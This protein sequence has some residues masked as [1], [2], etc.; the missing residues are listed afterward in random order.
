MGPQIMLSMVIHRD[1]PLAKIRCS[2]LNLIDVLARLSLPSTVCV[3]TIFKMKKHKDIL[4]AE[5]KET[6]FKKFLW[7]RYVNKHTVD[8]SKNLLYWTTLKD[9]GFYLPFNFF[10]VHLF[11]WSSSIGARR[12][13]L[14]VS[15]EATVFVMAWRRMHSLYIQWIH[16]GL[17]WKISVFLW[18][19]VQPLC[20]QGHGILAP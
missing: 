15:F 14:T 17:E 1:L 6:H 20:F 7:V 10:L 8:L 18:P 11:S 16:N 4:N 3:L 2:K 13:F 12:M 5:R 9:I 19:K